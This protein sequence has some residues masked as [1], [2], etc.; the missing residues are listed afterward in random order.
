M[1]DVNRVFLLGRLTRDPE[2]RHLASGT[3]VVNLGLAINHRYRRADSDELV[4]KVCFVKVTVFGPQAVASHRF[5]HKGRSVF[6]EG[7]LHHEKWTDPDGDSRSQL[8][9]TAARLQFL[10]RNES[11]NT[12]QDQQEELTTE[13]AEVGRV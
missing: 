12:Q 4:E 1:P 8:S 10:P 9:V 13:P 6:V 5:L 3:A 11:S 7:R 2:I